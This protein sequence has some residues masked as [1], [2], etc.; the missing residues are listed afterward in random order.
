MRRAAIEDVRT[1]A[2]NPEF[3][4]ALACIRRLFEK[5]EPEALAQAADR[6]STEFQPTCIKQ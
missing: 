5:Y 6:G 1:L 4:S 2:D 3:I